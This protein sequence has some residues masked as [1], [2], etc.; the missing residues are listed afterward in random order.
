[1]IFRYG[2]K[3]ILLGLICT[4]VFS[5]QGLQARGGIGLAAG[6][7]SGITFRIEK[8]PV[9]TIGYSFLTGSQWINGSLDFWILNNPIAGQFYWYFGIGGN[10]GIYTT[11]GMPVRL[12]AR[13]PIGIQWVPINLI[14]VYLEGAPGA[15]L[16]PAIGFDWQANLGIRFMI[17]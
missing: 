4:L 2:K 7:P 5:S 3:W 15:L 17:F 1:M 11:S 16:Y 9:V 13:V 14:E 10:V 12:G 6:Q 8:F